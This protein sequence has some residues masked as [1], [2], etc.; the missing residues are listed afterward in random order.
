MNQYNSET[1]RIATVAGSSAAYAQG[2]NLGCA[3]LYIYSC[4]MHR[5]MYTYLHRYEYAAAY[6]GDE[7]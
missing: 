4:Y 6:G 5:Y 1:H 7:L 3:Y 2:R